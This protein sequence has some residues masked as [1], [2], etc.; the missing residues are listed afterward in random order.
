MTALNILQLD[1]MSLEN[2]NKILSEKDIKVNHVVSHYEKNGC[3]ATSLA[4][5][6]LSYIGHLQLIVFIHFEC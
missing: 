5:Q 1:T 2:K 6:F 4:I 3:F